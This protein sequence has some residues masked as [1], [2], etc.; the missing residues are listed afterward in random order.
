MSVAALLGSFDQRNRLAAV[1]S[2]F[3]QQGRLF[4][5]AERL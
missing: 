3:T 5:S 1:P 2:H 4:D